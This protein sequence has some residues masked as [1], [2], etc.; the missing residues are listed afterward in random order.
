MSAGVVVQQMIVIFL[1]VLS[2]YICYKKKVV[3]DGVSKG[4]SALVIN[5][6][7][8]AVII[9]SALSRDE[10]ITYENMIIAAIA[11]AVVYF[12]F[13]LASLVIPRILRTKGDEKTHYAL[14]SL[15]GNQ[16]FVGIP[17]VSAVLGEN[18]LF[19]VSI[20]IVYFNIVFYTY[21]LVLCDGGSSKFSFK[22]FINAGN[23]SIII[24]LIIFFLDLR[25]PTVISDALGHMANATTFLALVVVGINLAQTK[26]VSI[27]TNAK[28]YLF[29]LL[30]F[31]LLPIGISFVLRIF[32]KDPMIY[33]VMILMA[34]V[35][36]A[37][38]PL[39]RVEEIG[40]DGRLI[41][42]GVIFSTI[43]ALV[44]IPIVTLFV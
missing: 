1:V 37:N 22:N 44:T 26:L 7:S 42:Q 19:Y 39:M 29:V 27:F 32:V 10:S 24:M 12:I 21:G 14:M 6:C 4:L 9:G 5:V 25:L 31:V 15:F 34:A 3:Q 8:P 43:G 16:A 41:S 23:I 33:G 36:V 40:G 35:P 28:L 38:S 2:G 20:R 17:V 30:R 18:A 13:F 11:G